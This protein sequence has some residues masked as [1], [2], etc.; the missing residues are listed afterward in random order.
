MSVDLD[1]IEAAALAA[2]RWG[3]GRWFVF[4]NP[5]A[6]HV[7]VEIRQGSPEGGPA[8]MCRTWQE[9][10]CDECGSSTHVNGADRWYVAEMTKVTSRSYGC[11]RKG[12]YD[13][14]QSILDEANHIALCSPS[15]VL[16][17]VAEVRRL[18]EA[19]GEQSPLRDVVTDA[20]RRFDERPLYR[21]S[22]A[23]WREL[24]AWACQHCGRSFVGSPG[25]P[26]TDRAAVRCPVRS[27]SVQCVPCEPEYATK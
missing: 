3:T 20:A 6:P 7:P 12:L 18:R 21:A 4:H 2:K 24:G 23:A 9:T 22:I 11:G 27:G 1:K 5:K 13:A 19:L 25:D 14:N 16:E 10:P 17:L 15:T 26:G 8:E